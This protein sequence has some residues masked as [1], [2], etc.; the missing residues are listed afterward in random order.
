M[1]PG[2][3]TKLRDL[4][5]LR[6]LHYSEA[7]RLSEVQAQRFLK[8]VGVSEPAVP[9]R[10]ITEL[11]R[12]RV[13]RMSPFP[14]SGATHWAQGQWLV[15]LNGAEPIGRQRF[16][17]AHELKHIIDHRFEKLVYSRFPSSDRTA[18]VE[19][20]CDF[21][22]GCLLMP[23]PW[24]KWVYCSGTQ[25]LPDLAQSFGVSQAAMSVR[26]NQIG[27]TPPAPRCLP[28]GS[29][30]TLKALSEIVTPRGYQRAA[31]FVI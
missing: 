29:D 31:S 1:T 17:L 24:V 3:I 21:F 6:P 16:S 11:P 4:M 10:V 22:S 2:V 13:S 28:I 23:R 15:V 27:L 8:M 5:P 19:Q 26:L 25:R 7:L 20:I 14:T 30:W 18:L 12:I 9:E